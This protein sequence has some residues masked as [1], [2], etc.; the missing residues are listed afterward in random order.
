MV[1]ISA[2]SISRM[3]QLRLRSSRLKAAA[4]IHPAVPPPTMTMLR[5]GSMGTQ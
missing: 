4:H 5:M 3:R 2:D 1:P